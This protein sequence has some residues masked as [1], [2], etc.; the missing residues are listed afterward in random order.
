LVVSE[1]LLEQIEPIKNKLR[2]LRHIIVV[3]QPRD[4]QLSYRELTE[5]SSV[6]LA[7]EMMSKDDVCFWLYS[8]GTTAFPKGAV[9][10]QHDMIVSAD[11]YAR[12]TLDIGENDRTFSVAKLFFA[13][14]LGNGLYFPFRVGAT[15]ILNPDKPDPVKFYEI[16]QE[17]RPTI[18]FCVPTGYASMLAVEN[19][20]E[21]FDTSSLRLCVS[22]GEALPSALFESWQEKF[23]VEILDG[24][25]STEIVH[26][27]IS[28]RPGRVKPGSTG[29]IVPG[30]EARIVDE[31]G[32]D[33]P[34][35]ET[36]DLLIKGDSTCAYYWNK[37]EQTKDTIEGHWIRTGDK[38][39]RDTDGYFWYQGRT[40]DMLKAG[41]MWVS[42]IEIEHTLAKHP[43]VLESAVI[44]VA[45]KE[46]L[47]KPKAFII[48]K[49]NHQGSDELAKQLQKFVKEKIGVYKYPRWIQFVSEIPETA[50]GKIQRYKLRES[51]RDST[52]HQES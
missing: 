42:P 38:Y 27:F 17:Y 31:N 11:L 28:N 14:G 13:Y 9:H 46:D 29:E 51:S 5:A 6:E 22:A 21:R 41:G 49:E 25:G 34:T 1:S 30:Y 52:F 19:A 20:A 37:H 26:I 45:D 44:G 4:D 36:G 8:S 43:F 39:L 18:F 23:G 16:I 15:T 47:I 50:T 33:M 3:G 2:Y 35:G 10:L 7:P 32:R 40:D 12:P 24:I 48:L